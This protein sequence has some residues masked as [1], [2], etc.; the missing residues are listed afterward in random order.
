M[1]IDPLFEPAVGATA[2]VVT[3]EIAQASPAK[4]SGFVGGAN[5][6]ASRFSAELSSWNPAIRTPD[7]DI[8]PEKKTIDARVRDIVRNDAVA[9]AGVVLHKDNI[10]G[11]QYVIS[12]KPNY[13]YLGKTA[14]W[15][16]K[17]QEEVETKFMMWAESPD[18]WVAANRRHTLTS[19]LRLGIGIKL[20]G[21]E[22]LIACEWIDKGP[23]R[24]YKTAVQFVDTDRLSNPN[25]LADT[26]NLRGGVEMGAHGE[27]IAYH[28]RQAHPAARN[29]PGAFSW[30][31]VAARKR[32]GRLQMAHIYDEN[33]PDQTRGL[34][35]FAVGLSDMKMLKKFRGVALQNAV[36]NATF[37]A[38]IES[39][40]P[41]SDE[42]YA[43]LGAGNKE[44]NIYSTIAEQYF[45]A[46]TEFSSGAKATLLDG[47]K[48]PHLM[49]G[50]KLQLRPA[51][52]SGALGTDFEKS[53]LRY[54]AS[55]LGVS[56]EEL[57]RNFADSN[58]SSARA[59]MLMTWKRMQAEKKSTADVMA[60]I[61]FRLWFEEAVNNNELET[62]T[63]SDPS[64]Y[65]GMNLDAYTT[66]EWIGASRGQIDEVKETQAAV[67]RVNNNLTTLEDELA[68][69]GK[70][71]RKVLLQK[72][73]EKELMDEYGLTPVVDSNVMNSLT[74]NPR[75]S[76]TDGE[77][78]E[79][80]GDETDA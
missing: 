59:A 51:G 58:Y 24:P 44:T 20:Y 33:R 62:V 1:N 49:P 5:D 73:A 10:V 38:S 68:K 57:S 26:L 67:L 47:V 28:I 78:K 21:G 30:K 72:K 16:T 25:G 35:D 31:R 41:S 18:K 80:P 52:T 65:D 12:C 63:R 39:E 42:V 37:A 50:M 22:S 32:W 64:I 40:L 61:V 15:A 48:V 36:L 13:T 29:D 54:I 77:A 66:C 7:Q 79:D 9:N 34:S 2:R 71:W 17:F 11:A 27:A 19:F 56:Y 70:D 74:A 60:N 55:T 4:Q 14:E 76:R 75:D 3:P 69:Q 46:V 45:G 8:L 53:C 43:R 23:R 6:A